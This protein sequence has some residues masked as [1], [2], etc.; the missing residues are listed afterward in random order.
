MSEE[1]KRLNNIMQ[2][3][4]N[5][6]IIGG[7]GYEYREAIRMLYEGYEYDE[8]LNWYNTEMGAV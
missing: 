4:E 5:T 8:V 7:H 3:V 6:I 2:F 1:S